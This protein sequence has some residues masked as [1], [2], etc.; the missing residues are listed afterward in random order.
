MRPLLYTLLAVL[1]LYALLIAAAWAWQERIVWQPPPGAPTAAVT[2]VTYA[3]EDGQPLFAWLVGDAKRGAGLVIAFH[4]NAEVAAWNVDWANEV[5]RRTGW[6]VMLP[7]YRGYGGL[8]GSPSHRGAMLDARAT[9][10]AAREQLGTDS[11]AIV[12]YGHSLGTAVAAELASEHRPAALVLLA[13]FTSVRDM[14]R[15]MGGRPL[16]MAWPLI[17]RVAFD[18]RA[19]VA[20]LD[21]PVWVAHGERDGVIPVRMGREVYSA[22]R[23]KGELVTFPRA[24]HNDVLDVERDAYWR[25]FAK[26]LAR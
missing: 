21:A 22:A 19:R 20:E 12:L 2:R 25:W 14:V 8:P 6:A 9:W 24:G 16:A 26:A 15:G 17:G 4:G 18:T 5:A 1:V 23:R 7:E 11:A 10:R 13:P 3:A